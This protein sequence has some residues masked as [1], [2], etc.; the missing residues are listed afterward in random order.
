MSKKY[1][2]QCPKEFA[3]QSAAFKKAHPGGIDSLVQGRWWVQPKFDGCHI[4]IDTTTGVATSR[5][6]ERVRSMDA[7]VAGVCRR[8]GKGFV[9]FGEAYQLGTTFSKI[10]GDFRR[11]SASPDLCIVAF[12]MVS[13]EAFRCGHSAAHYRHRFNML[14]HMLNLPRLD[15][16]RMQSS[17][18]EDKI[19][20]A[21][22][23]HCTED[24]IGWALHLK[25]VVGGYDGIILRDPDAGWEAG[26]SK[27][28]E[29][30]KVKPVLSLDLRVDSQKVEQRATKLGGYI[31]VSYKGVQ[32]DVGSGLTQAM[33]HDMQGRVSFVDRIAEIECMGVTPDGK[34][35]EPRFKGWRFDKIKADGE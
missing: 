34:L 29:V 19:L 3:D 12:D 8:I 18:P 26:D 13:A 30:I 15:V 11:H 16:P 24:V 5:T 9:V 20:T 22:T 2:N 1:L 21:Y 35:R 32:S 17:P 25:D 23:L 10:S 6:G 27:N 33:L 31:T 28:G 14:Q 7:Q 4:I